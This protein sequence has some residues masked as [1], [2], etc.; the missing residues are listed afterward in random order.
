MIAVPEKET[1]SINTK[2]NT[3]EKQQGGKRRTNIKEYVI[4]QDAETILSEILFAIC[5]VEQIQYEDFSQEEIE[6]YEKLNEQT[7]KS[8]CS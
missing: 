7:G 2:S 1:D 6:M 3:K 8:N 5:D 4:T